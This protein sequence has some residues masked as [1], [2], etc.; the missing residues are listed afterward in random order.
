MNSDEEKA[1]FEEWG[2]EYNFV[3]REWVSPL[4]LPGGGQVKIKQ[5]DLVDASSH[6]RSEAE[7]IQAIRAYGIHV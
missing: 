5:A 2:W 1:L 7:L 4:E 3:K 6:Q